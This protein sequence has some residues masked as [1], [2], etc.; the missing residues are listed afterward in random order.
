MVGNVQSAGIRTAS[1]CC[2]LLLL[3]FL[4]I[5]LD[6]SQAA[7][8]PAGQGAEISIINGG[9]TEAKAWPWQV[10]LTLN[11][12]EGRKVSARK[13]YF[14]AGSMIAPDLVMTAA[15]CVADLRKGQ[16][17]RIE[18]ITGR[19]WLSNSTGSSAFVKSR[20]MPRNQNGQSR[21]GSS[22]GRATWDVAL[23]KLKRRLPAQPIKLAGA[24]EAS[25]LSP[26]TLVKV[27]GWGVTRP[28]N[29]IGSN[30]LRA[31]NQVV[32]GDAV[33]RRDNGKTYRS[34]TMICLGGPSGNTSTCF[35]DS[36]GPMVARVSDGWRI[37]GVTSFGD[38]VCRPDLPSVDARVSGTAIRTWVRQTAIRASGVDPVGSDGASPPKRSWCRVPKLRGRGI[39]QAR[40]ALRRSG[41][42]LG[43]I[44]RV[45]FGLGK[46]GRVSFSS[47][48]Q[49]W[50]TPTGKRIRVWVNR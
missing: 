26:G 5:G 8:A 24:S 49:G 28:F 38:P 35:G 3:A 16:I 37:I 45:P 43:K 39:S 27:T 11:R 25:A 18:V 17:R 29:R 4:V 6:R 23:L 19:T 34:K 12:P 13:R 46:S 40:T 47:L 36:G 50:L 41:C 14:C 21:Y 7:Q 44:A 48:P 31:A 2:G 20:L 15:H 32:L 22:N 10:A 42:R 30:I 1:L 9:G 33:C